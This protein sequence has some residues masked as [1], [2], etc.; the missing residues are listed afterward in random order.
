MVSLQSLQGRDVSRR[1]SL[2]ILSVRTAEHCT[3]LRTKDVRVVE[4]TKHMDDALEIAIE[5]KIVST[6]LKEGIESIKLNLRGNRG[7][8]DR[9]F[10][11]M[12]E[13]YFMEVKRPGKEPTDLQ[14][15]RLNWL[16]VNGFTCGW[17]DNV[18]TGMRMLRS[19]KI[20]VLGRNSQKSLSKPT[21]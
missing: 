11:F 16:Y 9:L 7:W 15:Y 19:W 18:E 5:D 13:S 1:R 21:T 10:L 14:Q 3:D 12:G 20:S 6:A 17:T 8:P 2:L 4:H